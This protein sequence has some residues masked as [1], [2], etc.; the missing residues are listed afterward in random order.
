MRYRV[1]RETKSKQKNNTVAVAMDGNYKL[2]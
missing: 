2:Y 1:N